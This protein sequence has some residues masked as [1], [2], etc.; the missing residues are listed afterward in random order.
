MGRAVWWRDYNQNDTLKEW[1][2]EIKVPRIRKHTKKVLKTKIR[3]KKFRIETGEYLEMSKTL[4][5]QN[6]MEKKIERQ[7]ICFLRN[8]KS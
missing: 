6:S 7:F 8:Y 1:K 5:I 2:K 4:L 3:C